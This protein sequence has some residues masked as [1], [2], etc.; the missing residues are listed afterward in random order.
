MI[1]ISEIH[2]LY[3]FT[4]KSMKIKGYNYHY[5]D[6][7]KGDSPLVM[8][9]G[10]P[11]WS[12]FFRNL[13]RE[14]SKRHRV[15]A[16]DHLGCG[17]SDKPQDFPYRLE[18]H[19]DN[20]ENLLLNL[21][22]RNITLVVHDWG[23]AVGMGFAVRHPDRIARLVILNS[24]AFSMD[25]IPIRI[26]MCRIPWL[27]DKMI[28]SANLFVRA[29]L[30]MTTVKPMSP[31]VKKGYKFPY[32]TYDDRIAVLRFVQDI[33][34]DPE[35]ISY[36]VLLEIEHG[37][38]MFRELP[39]AIAWGMRDWCFSKRFL[40]RWKLYYPQAEVLELEDAGHYL[41]EDA[42]DEVIKFIHRFINH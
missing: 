31:L 23:G 36:E 5:L 41:L 3:P 16:P 20:L 21:D 12:F 7:G 14:F 26:A 32:Q 2:S 25:W 35:D 42:G 15:I 9:H 13:V 24:A 8:V 22:L 19:I 38:W 29:A 11:T 6:E 1:D 28:R 10:N 33:P 37:L 27:D 30:Q 34:L 18:T 17:L 40:N 39:V 4:S